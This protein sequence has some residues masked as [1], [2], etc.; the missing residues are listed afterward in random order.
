[1]GQTVKLPLLQSFSRSSSWRAILIR[2]NLFPREIM[3]DAE[4]PGAR[5][6]P[7]SA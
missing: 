1:M 7:R 4:D 2:V 3:R 6:L 5:A